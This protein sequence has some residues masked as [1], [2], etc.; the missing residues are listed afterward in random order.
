MDERIRTV[1][2]ILNRQGRYY[3]A[4]G[5]AGCNTRKNNGFGFDTEALAMASHR[6]YA[7]RSKKILSREDASALD[8]AVLE[9]VDGALAKGQS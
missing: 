7:G 5:F 8:G 6:R 2:V 1:Q 3:V 4:P 9:F